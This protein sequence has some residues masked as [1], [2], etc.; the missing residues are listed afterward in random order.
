MWDPFFSFHSS[1]FGTILSNRVRSFQFFS[2][3]QKYSEALSYA[4]T[5]PKYRN[6]AIEIALERKL[7]ENDAKGKLKKIK[8][9]NN[10]D[11]IRSIVA[12]N[13]DVR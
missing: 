1:R 6:A 13:M 10:D 9:R 3:K 7:L 8:G 11:I 5:V 4:V 12:E 2:A